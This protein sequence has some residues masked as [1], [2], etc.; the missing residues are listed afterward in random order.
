MSGVLHGPVG[1]EHDLGGD[2]QVQVP[3][4]PAPHE[5][6]RA[7]ERLERSGPLRV[8]PEHRHEDL[9]ALEIRRRVHLGHGHEPEPRV[10]ELALHDHG[11]LFLDE[12]VDAYEPLALHYV[13]GTLVMFVR[14]AC[15]AYLPDTVPIFAR[16]AFGSPH[17]T[18]T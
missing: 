8:R 18:S 10:L 16:L 13:P 2:P 6:P 14:L 9:G 12:L 17:R 11:D 15:L 4:Q 1:P 3:A 7:L 5:A